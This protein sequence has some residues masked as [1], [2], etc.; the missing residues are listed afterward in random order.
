MKNG[1]ELRRYCPPSRQVR[2]AGR[3][4]ITGPRSMECCGLPEAA[5]NGETFQNATVSGRQCMPSLENGEMRVFWSRFSMS[6]DA[7]MENLSI[8]ST[9]VKV[10]QSAN[11]GKKGIN[12]KL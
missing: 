9:S 11:G 10:H 4:K 3:P 12:R 8:D 1:S 7:D 6:A 5:L 2:K